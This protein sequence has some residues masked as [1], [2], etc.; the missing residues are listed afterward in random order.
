MLFW[1]DYCASPCRR[2]QVLSAV[3]AKHFCVAMGTYLSVPKTDK[4]TE[5]GSCR[6]LSYGM[7]GM[8]G[9]RRS[10]EDAHLAAMDF[11]GN[12]DMC[13]FGVFDGHGGA[14]VAKFCSKHLA[15]EFSNLKK[16]KDCDY[17][18]ALKDVF[19]RMDV[20][21]RDQSYASELAQVH[22]FT[23][24]RRPGVSPVTFRCT[25]VFIICKLIIYVDPI[26]KRWRSVCPHAS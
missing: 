24:R 13:M 12:T 25:C 11:N 14:E 3:C 5:R 10:M 20:L 16:F 4:E 15:E 26:C 1:K 19:H 18:G 9:W 22:R 8:Q 6:D 17:E 2:P 7:S 21:L 23:R